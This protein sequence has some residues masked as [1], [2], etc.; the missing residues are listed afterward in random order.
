MRIVLLGA[1]G[2]GKGTQAE[3]IVERYQI[4]HISTGDLLRAE[5]AAG[6][7]LGKQAKA[8]MDA[9][10]LVSDDIVLGM[11][12]DRLSKPETQHGFLLDGFPRTL[13]QAEGLDALLTKHGQPLDVTLLL[14]VDPDEIMQRLLARKRAD[15]TEET[16]RNRLQVYE[17]QTAPLIDYYQNQGKLRKVHGVGDVEAISKKIFQVLDDFA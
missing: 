7:P 6:T 5:V 11:I 16:I 10:E 13:A 14:D 1:P 4:T 17:N 9:G 12:E 8:I 3:R 15:D 2:S